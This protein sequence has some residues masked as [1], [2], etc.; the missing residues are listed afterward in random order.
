MRATDEGAEAVGAETDEPY[1]EA[2]DAGLDTELMTHDPE[3]MRDEYWAIDDDG[4]GDSEIYD[5]KGK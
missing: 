3:P 5:E 4:I 2:D 1:T